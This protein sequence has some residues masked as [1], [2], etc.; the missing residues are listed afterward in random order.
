MRSSTGSLEI[1]SKEKYN[2]SPSRY[3]RLAELL[4]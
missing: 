2:L 1:R 3:K 4:L